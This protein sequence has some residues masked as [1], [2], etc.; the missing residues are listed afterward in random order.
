MTFLERFADG[1]LRRQG[2]A[3]RPP[4]LKGCLAAAA[5]VAAADPAV[6]LARRSTLDQILDEFRAQEGFDLDQA[7]RAFQGSLD[8]LREDGAA[9]RRAALASLRKLEDDPEAVELLLRVARVVALADG[10]AS[11]QVKQ[12]VGDIATALGRSTPVLEA[13]PAAMAEAPGQIIVVGNEKG[14]TG[15]ST[16]A[17]HV[18]M[19]LAQRGVKVACID[20]DGRQATMS[21]FLT[22]RA[23]ASQQRQVPLVVPRYQ[24]LEAADPDAGEAEA[25]DDRSRFLGALAKLADYDVVVVDTPGYASRLAQL[26][27][28]VANVLVTPIND[29][30]VDVDALADIDIDRREVR[31]PSPFSRLVS[32]E[33][34]RRRLACQDEMDWIVLRNRIGHLDTRNTRDMA[35]LLSVLSQ[36]LGFRIQPGFSER[37]V[38]RGLYF[39]GLTLFD[40]AA[41]EIPHGGHASLERARREVR[42]LL[43]AVSTAADRSTRVQTE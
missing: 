9:A 20:L 7:V 39:R 8:R 2:W 32:E 30:F 25:V 34:D 23:A 13:R 17:I 5:L 15:K 24:R 10:D 6:S 40:L 19:G 33:R 26:A 18:A 38:F 28:S 36:R 29:S 3:R 11:P 21:R 42:E 31:A 43:D 16:T 35:A 4:L 12:I 14:G 1:V 27:Y 22:N 37:V 41:E